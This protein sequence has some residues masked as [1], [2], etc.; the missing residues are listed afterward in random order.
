MTSLLALGLT[1]I[2]SFIGSFGALFFKLGSR[3][4]HFDFKSLIFNWRLYVAVFFYVLSTVF[5][6]WAL[7]LPDS[8]LSV[9]YPFVS[10]TYVFVEL[11][12]IK[13]LNEKMNFWKWAGICFIILGVSFIGFGS[14]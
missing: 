8:A 3:E 11:L 12:S 4:L 2:A 14:R 1:V 10:L 6:I 5:F 9:I 7:A 13:F